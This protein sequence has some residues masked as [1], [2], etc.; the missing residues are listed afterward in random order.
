MRKALL[1]VAAV[2]ASFAAGEQFGLYLHRPLRVEC[3]GP[4]PGVVFQTLHPYGSRPGEE[5]CRSLDFGFNTCQ[6]E[7]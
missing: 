3:E 5:D 4:K 2:L 7:T 1:I 6:I